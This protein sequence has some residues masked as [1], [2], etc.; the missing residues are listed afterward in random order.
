M[1]VDDDEE[2]GDE[3]DQAIEETKI[4]RELG[5]FD[6]VMVWNHDTPWDAAEDSYAKGIDEWM[7]FANAVSSLSS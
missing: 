3:A 4:A 7:S 2:D 6:E 5:S 1:A